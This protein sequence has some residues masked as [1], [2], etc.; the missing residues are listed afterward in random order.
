[1]CC[2]VDGWMAGREEEGGRG[3][4]N[5]L[6]TCHACGVCSRVCALVSGCE[7]IWVRARGGHRS[8]SAFSSDSPLQ[9]PRQGLSL[10]PQ[11]C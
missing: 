9:S 5:H 11:A 6:G 10:A 8:V 1:M 2:V 3:R 7:C 4:K